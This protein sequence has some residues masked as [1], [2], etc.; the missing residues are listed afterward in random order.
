[1]PKF[2]HM[3]DIHVGAF[4]EPELKALVSEAFEAAVDECVS[5]RVDF[6]II[7]GD[8]FESNLPDLVS[9]KRATW[10]IKQAVDQGIRF[11]V[12]YGSHDF[13][14]NYASIVDVLESAGIFVKA[15]RPREGGERLRLDFIE[16]PSGAKI[17]GISGKKLSLDRE[18]YAALERETLEKES[19][20]KIFVFHG[21][22]E[23]MKPPTLERME[24]M[25]AS[26]L[27]GGFNYYA[28]GHVH[29]RALASL[30]GRPNVAYPG[31]LFATD[32]RELTEMARGTSRGF[33]VVDF[34][35][36]GVK[37][38]S[39]KPVKVCE[40]LE[41]RYS[42]EGKTA[43]EASEGLAGLAA[44]LDVKG[45]VV[46]LTVEGQLSSGR[47]S[48]VDIVR[49]KKRILGS[50]PLALQVNHTRLTSREQA[51]GEPL[52]KPFH[53][54]E[55]EAFQTNLARFKSDEPR[56]RGENGLS[57]SVE[58]LAA[59]KADKPENESK[60]EYQSRVERTGLTTLG[61]EEDRRC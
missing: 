58:L 21:A 33:Y 54:T 28:G 35:P 57:L 40:I 2:A 8:I 18:D 30:P 10:K 25:P 38:V 29:E 60:G 39:F 46:L 41:A 24:A 53:V 47:T 56:L 61:L 1:M 9:V 52:P 26:S 3:S 43:T 23:E 48:D 17:C 31:P 12:V 50:E 27:P 37:S 59:L 6:V 5:E 55:R 7:S 51:L 13:S 14:P 22:L 32:Y 36:S 11:Y 45:K 16:D 49:A 42:A 44:K 4:R 15:E 20:F 34:D 19:G